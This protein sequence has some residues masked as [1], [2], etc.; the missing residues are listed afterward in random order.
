MNISKSIVAAAGVTAILAFTPA[1]AAT[2]A[3]FGQVMSSIQA[4][5]TDATDIQAMTTLKSV[6]VVKV[7]DLA[8][9]KNMKA[10]DEAVKKNDADISSLRSAMTANAA[11]K[12][13]LVKA[14]VDVSTVVA[15]N[16]ASDGI[17]TV[18]VR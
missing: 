15:A 18:Y 7:N 1:I 5:K 3:N 10:L 13:A 9:G 12:T 8:K 16:V 2:T 11:V 14:N 4:S 17:L 6:N